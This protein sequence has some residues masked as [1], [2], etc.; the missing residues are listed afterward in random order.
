MPYEGVTPA[1]IAWMET[2]RKCEAI[3][4]KKWKPAGTGPTGFAVR[5]SQVDVTAY[6]RAASSSRARSGQHHLVP[7]QPL[8]SPLSAMVFSITAH[9]AADSPFCSFS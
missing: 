4:L 3:N 8:C 6:L 5:A 1:V 2:W 7:G 9:A